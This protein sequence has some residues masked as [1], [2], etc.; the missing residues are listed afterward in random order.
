MKSLD[1]RIF[2]FFHTFFTARIIFP[3]L[4]FIL[5]SI[6]VSHAVFLKKTVY[7][8]GIFY[9]SWLRSIVVDKNIDFTN[10]Y[11][12][13][14]VTQPVSASGVLTNKYAIGPAIFWSFSYI[15]LYSIL[16]G[17]GYE[18]PYE[19]ITGLSSVFFGLTSLL[20]LY[21]LLSKTVDERSALA[22]ICAIAGATPF[23]FYGSVDPVNSHV[24]AFFAST[25][26]LSYALSNKPKPL[27]IGLLLGC[28]GLA[29]PMDML[30]G[31]PVFFLYRKNLIPIF[32]GVFL[33]FFPQMILWFL[34]TG[35]IF[36][37]PYA[38]SHEGFAL[39][40]PHIVETLFSPSY[41]IFST[42]PIVLLS[43]IG[44]FLPWKTFRMN[45]YLVAG[46][47]AI[48]VYLIGS[49]STYWQGATYGN[50]MFLSF[51][52][53]VAFPLSRFLSLLVKRMGLAY[54]LLTTALPFSL[55]NA[56]GILLF[57]S[58]K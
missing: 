1:A 3:I 43:F 47:L 13:F 38:V 39:A 19:L 23:L 33:G 16:R 20:L 32:F 2:Q 30:V 51:L 31:L 22:S 46:T 14:S 49:W 50:R 11:A 37:S 4:F 48:A 6:M 12:H 56:I 29:R 18:F 45:K 24:I 25:V 57:L 28:V 36:V 21:R 27:V 41:G 58:A 34:Q 42:N 53:L 40:R 52:P 55:F 15:P 26:F 10:E 44:F 8:D 5:L 54:T 7:G 35:G 9:F 17:T